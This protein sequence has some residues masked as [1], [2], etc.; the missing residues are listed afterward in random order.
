MSANA[1]VFM[2]WANLKETFTFGNVTFEP[3]SLAKS[4]V[5]LLEST[6]VESLFNCF[7]DLDN[8]PVQDIAVCKLHMQCLYEK[9]DQTTIDEIREAINALVFATIAPKQ[10][11]AIA[12]NDKSNGPSTADRF[13]VYPWDLPQDGY[14]TFKTG[15]IL[16]KWR[17]DNLRVHKPLHALIQDDLP[18][19][20][21]VKDL[22]LVFKTR[23]I[24]PETKKRII[25]SLE[26]YKL[27]QTNSPDVSYASKL[28][29]LITAFEVLLPFPK[30]PKAKYFRQVINAYRSSNKNDI[31]SEIIIDNTKVFVSEKAL[32]AENFYKLRNKIVHGDDV[33][34]S[35]IWFNSDNSNFLNY[36]LVGC[37]LFNECISRAMNE[38]G[39]KNSFNQQA[40]E[41]VYRVIGWVR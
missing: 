36:D 33:R 11:I 29:M 25:K 12:N 26:W 3:W 9:V 41:R 39:S 10:L 14:T 13:C 2:P 34:P 8:L 40:W 5:A 17:L 38:I 35:D 27:S 37:I 32:W 28:G 21:M 1:I 24:E 23:S 4:K 30:A 22:Q 20:E 15:M 16:H 6:R 18:N 19:K 7:Y 31:E